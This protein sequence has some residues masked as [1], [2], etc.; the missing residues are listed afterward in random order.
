[1][2][3]LEKQLSIL[4]NYFWSWDFKTK[5]IFEKTNPQVWEEVNH[6]PVEFVRV[7]N[8]DLSELNVQKVRIKPSGKRIAYLCMEYAIHDSLPI[9]SGGLGVLAGDHLKASSDL[10]VDV[11]AFGLLYKD[12]YFHQVVNDNGEQKVESQNLDLDIIPTQRVTDSNGVPIILQLPYYSSEIYIA[13]WLVKVGSVNLYL[14]DTNLKQNSDEQRTI[15]SQLY[16]GDINTRLHQEYI[17]GVGSIELINMLDLEFDVYHF[18]EGHAA[19]GGI[20]LW[21]HLIKSHQT[22]EEAFKNLKSKILFTTHTPVPAGHDVFDPNMVDSLFKKYFQGSPLEFSD[23]RGLGVHDLGY[24][25]GFNMTVLGMK[26]AK[27]VNGVS[28]LNATALNRLWTD[29]LIKENLKIVPVTNGVHIQTFLNTELA[30][31]LNLDQIDPHEYV[32]P[33]SW[34]TFKISNHKLWETHYLA[35]IEMMEFFKRRVTTKIDRE[36][37]P[38]NLLPYGILFDPKILTI[39]FARRFAT[40]KRSTLIFENIE[41]IKKLVTHPTRPI[42]IVFSGKPHPADR[43]GQALLQ[44][45]YDHAK[46]PEFLGRVA[47]V[48]DYDMTTAKHLVSGV[49]VWLNTPRVPREASGTSGMKA[50]INGV[51]N[52]STYDGW[53]PEAFNEKNGWVIGKYDPALSPPEQD[54]QD[55]DS[56]LKILEHKVIPEYYE[57]NESGLPENWIQRMRNSIESVGPKFSSHRMVLDYKTLYEL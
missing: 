31:L 55:W 21:K 46:D 14:L 49:D 50:S 39:G 10:G 16:G 51:L 29:F 4:E 56:L 43:E 9:Y 18:N 30:H 38:E 2:L 35:K 17:L 3:Q 41:R 42:Q 53:W 13:V 52:L 1:M 57:L 45:V 5:D 27:T 34:N 36:I 40:Y 33:E 19:F 8:F 54:Q 6:N 23:I 11:T 22:K 15:T 44:M 26:L 32:K 7:T 12:G 47:F 24:G 28:K 20:A 48:P 37:N 25:E